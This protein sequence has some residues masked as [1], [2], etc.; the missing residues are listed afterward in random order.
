MNTPLIGIKTN[1]LHNQK[2]RELLI[3]R[4]NKKDVPVISVVLGITPR[5]IICDT[6]KFFPKK[7]G[8]FGWEKA[9]SVPEKEWR[10]AIATLQEEQ[11]GKDTIFFTS[12]EEAVRFLKMLNK[13]P[14]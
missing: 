13:T 5:T 10:K 11:Y 4:L 2:R 12:C 3:K 1:L 8:Y 14:R 9:D 7:I 6:P